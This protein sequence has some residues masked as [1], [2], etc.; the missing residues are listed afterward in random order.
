MVHG[1]DYGMDDGIFR[2]HLKAFFHS[3][4]QLWYLLTNTNRLTALYWPAFVLLPQSHRVKRDI[5]IDKFI[6]CVS[7][8]T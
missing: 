2:K 8:V 5:H 3:N 1:M 4:S 6:I 7:F